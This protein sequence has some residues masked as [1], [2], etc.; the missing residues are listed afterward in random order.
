MNNVHMSFLFS[1]PDKKEK[2]TNSRLCINPVQTIKFINFFFAR[3]FE[4][5]MSKDRNKAVE[6]IL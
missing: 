6:L 4:R 5:K 3:T 2:I 1:Y